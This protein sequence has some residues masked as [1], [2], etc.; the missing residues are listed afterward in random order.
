MAWGLRNSLAERSSSTAGR[1]PCCR[2]MDAAALS[3]EL[4]GQLLPTR[5]AGVW[6][7]ARCGCR[8][9]F[10]RNGGDVLPARPVAAGVNGD[11]V[12]ELNRRVRSFAPRVAVLREVPLMVA[13][14]LQPP[15]GAAGALPA[16]SEACRLHVSPRP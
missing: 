16:A 9:S 5:L 3:V 15:V 4:T 2:I 8:C 14:A 11:K 10:G 13:S 12:I 6:F 1:C 7:P